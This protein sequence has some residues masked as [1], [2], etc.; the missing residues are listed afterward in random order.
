MPQL[1]DR[2]DLESVFPAESL[3]I[4]VPESLARVT[5]LPTRTLLAEVG[6]PDE[7]AAWLEV[8]EELS[9]GR[10]EA[11][12]EATARRYPGLGLD[13]AHWFGLGGICEDEVVLDGATGAVHALPEDAPPYLLNSSFEAFLYFLYLLETERPNYDNEAAGGDIEDTGAADRLRT[14][15]AQADPAA[16]ITDPGSTWGVVLDGVATCLAAY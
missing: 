14:L 12:Y 1:V 11:G 5:H 9:E 16:P 6:I 13:V 15:M 8:H 4:P 7:P 3:I 10:L 2:A